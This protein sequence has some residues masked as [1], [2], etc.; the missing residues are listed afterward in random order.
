[1]TPLALNHAA[2]ASRLLD[3]HESVLQSTPHPIPTQ[4][5]KNAFAGFS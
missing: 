3:S 2:P 1:M 4:P 5:Q